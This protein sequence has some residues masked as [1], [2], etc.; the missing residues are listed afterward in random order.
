LIQ[1]RYL[2]SLQGIPDV[3]YEAAAIDGAGGWRKLWN[4]TIPLMSPV[5]VFMG[6]TA[7]VFR[8]IDSRVY[9]EEA[10]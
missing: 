5:I 10:G 1:N 3:F 2:V 7:L 9:C 4:V 8:E 6:L